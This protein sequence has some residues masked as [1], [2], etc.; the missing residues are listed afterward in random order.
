MH[1]LATW[2]PATVWCGL[3]RG[4]SFP[5]LSSVG[6]SWLIGTRQDQAMD[7][8]NQ[9]KLVEVDE[10]AYGNVQ[11]SHVTQQLRLMYRQDLVDRFEFE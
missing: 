7:A 5:S 2:R 1:K 11:Q 9:L 6:F 10:K 3:P 8:V 4:P